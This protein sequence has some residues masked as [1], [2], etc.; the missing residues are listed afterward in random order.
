M[1][2]YI[3][4]ISGRV[5]QYDYALYNAVKGASMASE[6]KLFMPDVQDSQKNEGVFSL[7][8]LIPNKYKNSE[9]TFKRLFK[10]LEGMLNYIII[11][12]LAFFKKPDVIHLQWL[13]FLEFCSIEIPL[14]KLLA[15]TLPRSKI[16]LTIHNLYPHN[17]DS[18]QIEKYKQR[19]DKISSCFDGFIVHTQ[20]TKKE[21][22]DAYKIE[23]K[24][25]KVIHHGVFAPDL[26]RLNRLDNR[27]R[28]YRLISYGQQVP[29]KG[30]DILLDAVSL[31]P[32]EYRDNIEIS[33]IGKGPLGYLNVLKQK[34]KNL[35]V[36]W[37]LYFVDDQT[38]YQEIYNAD[39]IVLPYRN[40]SQSGVLLLALHFNKVII[41]SDLPAF[42]E[43]MEGYP[44]DLF[45]KCDDPHSLA[46]VI[47]RLLL[48]KIEING[49][50]SSLNYL[51]EKYSWSEAG[52]LT[53]K[54]YNS[55]EIS[56]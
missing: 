50:Y 20:S 16:I 23:E 5:T 39:T 43:T 46:E 44:Q 33:I 7:L 18:N 48:N 56:R 30:T 1:R 32:K 15:V 19:F 53:V 6:V 41:C 38:L 28:K 22:V 34:A 29:Y 21:V 37:K 35:N 10:A 9:S 14:I 45:F 17:Y 36:D 40:I 26:S 54:A 13:P 49:I 8:K 3:I 25:I 11:L 2:V 42:I 52:K 4:D 55:F 12:L 31:L 24:R 27:K 47:M 51:R